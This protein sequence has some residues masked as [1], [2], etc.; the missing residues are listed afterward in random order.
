MTSRLISTRGS[1]SIKGLDLQGPYYHFIFWKWRF[2]Y[3]IQCFSLWPL[4]PIFLKKIDLIQLGFWRKQVPNLHRLR[5]PPP[6]TVV[7]NEESLSKRWQSKIRPF[8]IRNISTDA[9]IP[10][11]RKKC[12]EKLRFL[13][14]F[15]FGRSWVT[16]LS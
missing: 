6:N 11:I 4:E 3:C 10:K 16:F 15:Q 2:W 5:P 8:P 1:K 13:N 9:K 14:Y 7:Q 12:R